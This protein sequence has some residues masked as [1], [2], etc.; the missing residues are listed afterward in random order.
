LGG[1]CPLGS[2]FGAFL[3]ALK[4][5]KSS[6]FFSETQV[7][8]VRFA[9]FFQNRNDGDPVLCTSLFGKWNAAGLASSW[10]AF[11]IW[12]SPPAIPRPPRASQTPL[13]MSTIHS[14]FPD[15][16]RGTTNTAGFGWR[17]GSGV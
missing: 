9:F 4:I 6:C 17:G 14:F 11:T 12:C 16:R 2:L 7:Q 10:T 1:F 15:T 13:H 3:K 5:P 8:N